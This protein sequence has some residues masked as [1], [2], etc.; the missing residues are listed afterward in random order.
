MT[1]PFSLGPF[2]LSRRAWLLVMVLLPLLLVFA[3]VAFRSGPLAPVRVTAVTVEERAIA[4][5]LFGIAPRK[6]AIHSALVRS[7]RD[8]LPVL[9]LMSGTM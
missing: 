2:T 1:L 4:P 9:P 6:H 8:A 5:A 3:W 7:R